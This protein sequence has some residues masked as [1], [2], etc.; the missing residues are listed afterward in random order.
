MKRLSLNDK[1]FHGAVSL[2]LS[3][4]GAKPWRIPYTKEALFVPNHI[5]GK[6]EDTAGVRFSLVSDTTTV[7]VTVKSGKNAMQMDC[8]IDGRLHQTLLIEAGE[9]EFRIDGLPKENKRIELYL[10]QKLPVTIVSVWIDDDAAAEPFVDKRPRW[11][12]YGSSITQCSAAASPSQTWPALSAAGLNLN[13]TCLGFGGNCHLEPMV[14]RMIRDQPADYLS[15]CVG[16]N[17]MGGGSLSA[18][19]FQ[20]AVIG[21]IEIVREK[22]P[23]TPYAVMS[24]IFSLNRE[25]AENRVDMTLVKMREQIAEA[26]AKLQG[27]GDGNLFYIDGLDLMGG[28]FDSYM[29]DHL[30]P[31][32]EGYRIMAERFMKLQPFVRG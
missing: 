24:P 2:Q 7:L 3:E 8:C 16:I 26:V 32:A 27:Y 31:N 17:I 21:F 28:E 22:H 14:A 30:H 18:R 19:T 5:G 6:A 29:P 9:T 15:M 10:S 11:I 13:L 23:D 20:S 4:E 12:T 25:T 1:W